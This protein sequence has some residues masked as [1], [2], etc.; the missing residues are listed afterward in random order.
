MVSYHLKNK[1][2]RH[3]IPLCDVA[4]GYFLPPVSSHWVSQAGLSTPA[5]FLFVR[6]HTQGTATLRALAALSAWN[7]LPLVN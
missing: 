4:L 1:T 2:R 3:N 6:E 5:A 7:V